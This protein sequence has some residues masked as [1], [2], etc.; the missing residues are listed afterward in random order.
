MT[1]SNLTNG[2]TL[3]NGEKLTQLTLGDDY[4]SAEKT[5]EAFGFQYSDDQ[6]EH[7]AE[8]LPTDLETLLLLK[9]YGCMLAAGPNVDT[10]YLGVKTLNGTRPYEL[11]KYWYVK[12]K[13]KFARTDFVKAARWMIIRKTPVENSNNKTREEQ[14][15][16]IPDGYAFQ[17]QLRWCMPWRLT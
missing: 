17:T 12:N 1:L 7:L 4:L 6:L 5:A 15:E 14:L 2:S 13:E 11:N 8:T 10:N 3:P 9:T 16:L